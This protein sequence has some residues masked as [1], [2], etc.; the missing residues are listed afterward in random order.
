MNP[1]LPLHA[2]AL[3]SSTLGFIVK[4]QKQIKKKQ[5]AYEL[6][7]TNDNRKENLRNTQSGLMN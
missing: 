4:K 6:L 5:M 3:I 7:G 2:L 1:V